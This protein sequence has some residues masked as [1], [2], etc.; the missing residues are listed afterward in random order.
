SEEFKQSVIQG[1]VFMSENKGPYLF[2]CT[3]GKDR[4][5]FYAALLGSLMGGTKN[6]IIKDYM[7]SYINY[8]HVKKGTEQYKVI[9]EDVISMLNYIMS[10]SDLDNG[11]LADAAKKYLISGGMTNTQIKNLKRNL[12]P[13]T[14]KK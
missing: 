9:S 12:S 1:A 10:T 13:K 6:Q 11:K 8:Y 4:T 14:I 5:G 3:E 7:E 2:H